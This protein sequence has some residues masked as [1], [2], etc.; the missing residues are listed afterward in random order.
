MTPSEEL[1]LRNYLRRR[2]AEHNSKFSR[3][4]Y[5]F[6]EEAKTLRM[7]AF[8][9]FARGKNGTFDMTPSNLDYK[10]ARQYIAETGNKLSPYNYFDLDT[11]IAYDAYWEEI[12]GRVYQTCRNRR[13]QYPDVKDFDT[14]INYSVPKWLLENAHKESAGYYDVE[15]PVKILRDEKGKPCP[16]KTPNPKTFE[17]KYPRQMCENLLDRYLAERHGSKS[18]REIVEETP[19]VVDNLD[20]EWFTFRGKKFCIQNEQIFRDENMY[21]IRYIRGCSV[22]GYY[23]LSGFF[24]VDDSEYTGDLYDDEGNFVHDR[25]ET[26]VSMIKTPREL[27]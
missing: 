24:D 23:I 16:E 15:C 1:I 19:E 22:D 18:P 26:G 5:G 17:S 14:A 7:E 6:K 13:H 20:Y 12:F 3:M 4:T 27:Q 11:L 9:K 21:P 2:I 10:M 25:S 8:A